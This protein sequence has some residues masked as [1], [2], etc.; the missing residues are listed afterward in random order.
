MSDK[1]VTPVMER[2]FHG[3][4][5][6]ELFCAV[7]K[8][9]LVFIIKLLSIKVLIPIPAA[10]WALEAELIGEWVFFLVLVMVFAIRSFEKIVENN[11][12]K[13]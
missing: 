10:I 11:S 12:F 8:R 4:S 3:D 6:G 7:P 13:F 5:F 2:T 1:E 9:I